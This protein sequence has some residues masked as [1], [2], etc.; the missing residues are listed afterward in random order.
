MRAANWI[1]F[2]KSKSATSLA[3]CRPLCPICRRSGTAPRSQ[4]HHCSLARKLR[5]EPALPSLPRY[6]RRKSF[7]TS[8][9]PVAWHEYRCRISQMSV[10]C[11]L[12]LEDRSSVERNTTPRSREKYGVFKDKV[13]WKCRNQCGYRG[14]LVRSGAFLPRLGGY[15]VP[16]RGDRG[17]SAVGT[18]GR[19][20]RTKTHAAVGARPICRRFGCMRACPSR[21]FISEVF[22]G[23]DIGLEKVEQAV[24]RVYSCN[25]EIGEF[26]V[27]DLRF[28]PGIRS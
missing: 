16:H 10:V 4:G 12:L 8:I 5:V 19:R 2:P 22:R 13:V 6:Q 26:D 7:I 27:N 1:C 17:C 28:R 25:L 23:E 14:L 24:Y 3:G 21:V 11:S 20:I 15:R 18:P 9:F